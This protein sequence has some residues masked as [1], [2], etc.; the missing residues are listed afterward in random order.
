[1]TDTDPNVPGN[2]GGNEPAKVIEPVAGEPWYKGAD[3]ETVGY[4]QNRGLDKKDA[5]EAALAAIVAHRNAEAKLGAP[6]DQLLRM[7]KDDGDSAAREAIYKRLGRPDKADAYDLS[8]VKEHGGSDD[9]VKFVQDFA[10]SR[11]MSKADGEAMGK[12]FVSFAEKKE[13]SDNGQE[14]EKIAAERVKLDK[15]WGFNK[16]ANLL[17]AKNAAQKLGIPPEAVAALEKASGYYVTMEALRKIGVATGEARFISNDNNNNGNVMTK[18]GAIARKGE[19]MRDNDWT[20]KYLAG[21]VNAVRE[22]TN[23][24]TIITSSF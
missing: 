12:D 17:I 7:P 2:T 6:A 1:M 5:K 11:G 4:L 19:L 13:Q 24:N 10:F 14:A 22:M 18:D 23:L 9:F 21:D 15:E 16:A 8:Y 3:A 20:K